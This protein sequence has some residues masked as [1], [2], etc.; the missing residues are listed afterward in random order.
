VNLLI[1]K[2]ILVTKDRNSSINSV[3]K[4]I[5]LNAKLIFLPTIKIVPLKPNPELKEILSAQKVFDFLIFTSASAVRIFMDHVSQFNYEIQKCKIVVVGEKTEE[6]C[7]KFGLN[8]SLMPETY[9]ADGLIDLLSSIELSN[10]RILIPGSKISSKILS[11]ELIKLGA[12]VYT[13]PIYD[14]V[15]N[16]M[17]SCYDEFSFVK[18]N[19]PN[20]FI[21]TSPSS[22]KNYLSI[23]QLDNPTQYFSDSIICAMGKTTEIEINSK[24]VKVDIVPTIST[25]ENISNEIVHYYENIIT[26]SNWRSND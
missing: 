12:L 22:F 23:F 26:N 7:K 8:V 16:D 14:V 10:K 11:E 25:L 5:D 9:S 3:K 15:E 2:S 1:N 13:V 18:N 6:V 24:G 19:R 21:F 17:N 20:I 4:L